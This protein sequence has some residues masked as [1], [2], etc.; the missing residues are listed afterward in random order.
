MLNL[1]NLNANNQD[2][3]GGGGGEVI[4]SLYNLLNDDGANVKWLNDNNIM[5]IRPSGLSNINKIRF[6]EFVGDLLPVVKNGTLPKLIV[7][8]KTVNNPLLTGQ[9]ITPENIYNNYMLLSQYCN[10]IKVE[11]DWQ[12]NEDEETQVIYNIKLALDVLNAKLK[13]MLMPLG[14]SAAFRDPANFNVNVIEK[15]IYSN[16]RFIVLPSGLYSQAVEYGGNVANT[17]RFPYLDDSYNKQYLS[18]DVGTINHRLTGVEYTGYLGDIYSVIITETNND[19]ENNNYLRVVFPDETT[20]N[21]TL[22]FSSGQ[23]SLL[24][25]E[26]KKYPHQSGLSRS[27]S[28]SEYGFYCYVVVSSGNDTVK[29]TTN[30]NQTGFNSLDLGAVFTQYN[31]PYNWT[32]VNNPAYIISFN[33]SYESGSGAIELVGIQQATEPDDEDCQLLLF[34]IKW[35]TTDNPISGSGITTT[36]D[37]CLYQYI[38]ANN[39]A[40]LS[41]YDVNFIQ[42]LSLL[43]GSVGYGTGVASYV[44]GSDNYLK[45][46]SF[47]CKYTTDNITLTDS[48]II[49]NYRIRDNGQEHAITWSN[50]NG[51]YIMTNILLSEFFNSRNDFTIPL[52]DKYYLMSDSS[53]SG[54]LY[55]AG[56]NV[57]SL[58]SFRYGCGYIVPDYVITASDLDINN[59]YI[60]VKPSYVFGADVLKNVILKS[61]V[62]DA[63]GINRTNINFNHLSEYGEL[64]EETEDLITY[65]GIYTDGVDIIGS[66]NLPVFNMTSTEGDFIVPTFLHIDTSPSLFEIFSE[67]QTGNP[68]EFSIYKQDAELLYK[69]VDDQ[70]LARLETQILFKYEYNDIILNVLG[71]PN[72][73]GVLYHLNDISRIR[74][75]ELQT[76]NTTTSILINLTQED[77]KI[78]IE[79]LKHLYGKLYLSV[80]WEQ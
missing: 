2:D 74:F 53:L 64:T 13:R 21:T 62:Y 47:A 55:D 25:N 41:G 31:I 3:S 43:C 49:P 69:Y 20:F 51:R 5:L 67:I 9:V 38:D 12:Y 59:N 28:G 54:I 16:P 19:N 15:S 66:I 1:N 24:Y 60:G 68:K 4:N 30:E 29:Y 52:T 45:V 57:Q 26:I 33:L 14:Y 63:S 44:D 76:D 71:F 22:S 17:F 35:T 39:S 11:L 79:T 27:V 50:Y 78:D 7:E 56:Y 36:P 6:R 77:E 70:V 80:D 32:N 34:Y 65:S 72:G 48:A 23:K 61:S 8:L 42:K 58:G 40:V 10:L 18:I 73:D 37:K 75:K 46:N